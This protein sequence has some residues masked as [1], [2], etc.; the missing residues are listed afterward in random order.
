MTQQLSHFHT[1]FCVKEQEKIED[2]PSISMI[3]KQLLKSKIIFITLKQKQ[4]Y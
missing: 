3:K 4:Q 1:D 2:M